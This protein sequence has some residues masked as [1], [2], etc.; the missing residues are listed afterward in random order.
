MQGKILIV[1]T[2]ATNRI[3]LKVKLASAYYTVVQAYSLA[4]AL[5]A[6]AHEQPDLILTATELGDGCASDLAKQLALHPTLRHLPILAVQ[7]NANNCNKSEALAAGVHDVM[8]KPIE[9]ALLLGRVRSLIRAANADRE[10]RLRDDTSRAL[11]LAEPAAGYTPAGRVVIVHGD[12]VQ[13][14]HWLTK[15]RPYLPATAAISPPDLALKQRINGKPPDAFVLCLPTDSDRARRMLELVSNL[16][17]NGATRNAGLLVLQS[18]RDAALGANALDLGADDLMTDGFDAAELGLRLKALIRRK[19]LG[20][21][22]RDSVRSGLRAALY[23]PLTGLHNRR[24]ALPHLDR[25]AEHAAETGHEFAVMI[26]DMDH[27]KSINDRFG[28]ASGDAVLV[29]TTRRLRQSLRPVD[30]VARLGGEEFLIV[31]P[32]TPLEKARDAAARLCELISGKAFDIPGAAQAISVT[33]SIGLAMGGRDHASSPAPLTAQ[34][35]LDLADKALY[36][37]KLKG[38]NRVT[39]SRPAA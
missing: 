39:L 20:D 30:L 29:E 15:L 1:D 32:N 5:T 14:H 31:M 37:A 19:Y 7:A 8:N 17:A 36:A 6:A 16:R 9:D 13:G 33:L 4:S 12:V 2:V 26:A 34:T 27:F 24:Y 3:V 28:H 11:G 25:V 10:W 35:L 38:R 21:Q 22:M 18:R 23:D